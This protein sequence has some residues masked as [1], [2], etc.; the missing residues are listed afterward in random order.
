MKIYL[1]LL[2]LICNFCYSQNGEF[3]TYSNGLIYSESSISKL[4]KIVDSLHLKFKVCD[5]NKKFKAVNQTR[6][7]HIR[8][9]K[10]KVLEAKKI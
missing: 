8:L 7:N 3:E 5:Y 2:L 10:I 4:K 9:N 6:A 1:I